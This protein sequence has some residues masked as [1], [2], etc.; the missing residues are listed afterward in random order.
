[1]NQQINQPSKKINLEKKSE[2]QTSHQARM[3]PITDVL[4]QEKFHKNTWWNANDKGVRLH[5]WFDW[6]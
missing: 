4:A 1:M 3:P 2:I 6:Y 5:D